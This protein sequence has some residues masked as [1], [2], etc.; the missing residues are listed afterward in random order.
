MNTAAGSRG[1]ARLF[2]ARSLYGR[3]LFGHLLYGHA[4]SPTQTSGRTVRHT[5]TTQ[6][7]T[8]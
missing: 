1:L 3:L 8:T 6:A 5:L 4:C 7:K 2:T